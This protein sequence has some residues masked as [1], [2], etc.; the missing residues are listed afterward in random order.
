ME[1]TRVVASL[2]AVFDS[3]DLG[4]SMSADAASVVAGDELI[5]TVRVSNVGP[6]AAQGVVLST[7][8]P[9]GSKCY[10]LSPSRGSAWIS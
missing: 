5:Y 3:A 10:P 6:D 2:D 8:F 4:V 1:D 9:W 7:C